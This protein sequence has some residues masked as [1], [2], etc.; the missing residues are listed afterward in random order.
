MQEKAIELDQLN[1]VRLGKRL[2]EHLYL[3][4]STMH[5]LPPKTAPIRIPR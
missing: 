2:G 5:S 3:H 4:I 1:D